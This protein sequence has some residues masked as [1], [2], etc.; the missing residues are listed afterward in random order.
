MSLEDDDQ[1][2]SEEVVEEQKK[3][4]EVTTGSTRPKKGIQWHS[5]NS[6][7]V[8]KRISRVSQYSIDEIAAVWGDDD[9]ALLRKKELK[10]AARDV[11]YGRRTSDNLTFS[12][13][14]I[15]DMVGLGRQERKE[16]IPI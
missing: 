12:T 10:A 15:R 4:E 16:A 13:V 2:P 7:E 11:K 1:K 14:G 3:E 9:E 8:I 6:I 5:R